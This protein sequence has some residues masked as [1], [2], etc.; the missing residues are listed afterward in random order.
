MK[1]LLAIFLNEC[2]AVLR[3]KT[4]V[5]LLIAGVAWMFTAPRFF[6]GDGTVSGLREMSLHYSLGGV[7][8]LLAVTLLISATGSIAKER[9]AKRLALTMVRPVRY[10]NIALGK[11]L[12]HVLCGALVLA[13]CAAIE[14]VR[15]PDVTCR[16]V[17]KPVMPTLR[18][19]AESMYDYYMASSNTP[20][21]V[22]AA[23]KE[24]V[25]RLLA[26]RAKDRYD[27][28]ETNSCWSWKFEL[29]KALDDRLNG[30]SAR[31]RF[32]A[33]FDQREDVRGSLAYEGLQGVVSNITQSVIEIPMSVSSQ[34]P[35]PDGELIFR[36]DGKAPVMLRPRRDVELL[37]PGDS[38][39]WNL[40]RAYVE[41]VAMLALLISFG[42]FLGASL[43]R[44]AA[45]FTAISILLLS[46]MAPSVIDQYADELESDKVDAVGLAITRVAMTVTRPV[47]SLR[48][49]E[50]VSLDE[51]VEPKEVVSVVLIDFLGLPLFF[52]LLS[53]LVIPRKQEF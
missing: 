30:Y 40:A 17:L 51:C 23:R 29:P 9:V 36:N 33:N 26:N 52:M 24:V 43:G 50:A 47:S 12:A 2:R 35:S 41:L 10:F 38:F 16:H 22:K 8:A 37:T 25:I 21:K 5:M 46:E 4:L 14:G 20:A 42:I 34:P 6:T 27:T 49:L 18:Q 28:V 32:S 3:S 44:P 11:T 31:L 48:P 15:S 1:G 13:V 53:A 45:L 19:E 39:A 7:A